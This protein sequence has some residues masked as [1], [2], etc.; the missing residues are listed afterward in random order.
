MAELSCEIALKWMSLDL[1][2]DKS[3]LVQVMA[4]CHQATSHYLSQCWPRSL[5]PYGVTRP[6][7]VN[8]ECAE[9]Y[10]LQ[11][12][13]LYRQSQNPKSWFRKCLILMAQWSEHSA[14]NR[15]IV[16]SSPTRGELL[17]I[18]ESFG[19]FKNN[20]SAVE[21]GWCCWCMVGNSCWL[22]QT[23]EHSVPN[24][25]TPLNCSAPIIN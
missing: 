22:L 3:T 15:G 9:F 23:R 10:P 19:S 7:W 1:I 18:W 11:T 24:R 4:W 25:S 8:P 14:C 6:Q 5:S 20:S 13:Y 21:N 16:G 2:D 12:K 17:S